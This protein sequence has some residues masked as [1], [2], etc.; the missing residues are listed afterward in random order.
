MLVTADY[1]T[2]YGRA[3]CVKVFKNKQWL[4]K[5]TYT[6]GICMYYDEENFN[7]LNPQIIWSG[8]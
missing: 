3:I 8:M 2:K 4:M 7:K 5:T 1:N 6:N